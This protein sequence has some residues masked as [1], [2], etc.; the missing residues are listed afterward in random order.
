MFLFYFVIYMDTAMVAGQAQIVHVCKDLQLNEF[1]HK[2][3]IYI[4]GW[5]WAHEERIVA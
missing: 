4:I 1:W 3:F 2:S 5:C